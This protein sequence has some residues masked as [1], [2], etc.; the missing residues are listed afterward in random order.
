MW[1]M[2]DGENIIKLKKIFYILLLFLE[3][4][5]KIKCN[6]FEIFFICKYKGNKLYLGEI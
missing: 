6:Y 4:R 1:L 2:L 5:N 3:K